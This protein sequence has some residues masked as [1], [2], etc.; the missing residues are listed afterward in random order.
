MGRNHLIT[1]SLRLWPS[2]AQN[3]G[4]GRKG[5]GPNPKVDIEL[6]I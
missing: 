1:S 2:F 3:E 5:T 4:M 6:A